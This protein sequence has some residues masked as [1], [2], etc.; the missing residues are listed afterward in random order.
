FL[1]GGASHFHDQ[2]PLS[3]FEQPHTKYTE[4]G[5]TV[6]NLPENFYSSDYFTDKMMQ[7]VSEQ[8]DDHPFFA[9]L[10]FTSPHDPLQVPDE[11]L[12]K[13][14]GMYDGG[15]DSIR[16]QRLQRMKE[17]G[18][19]SEELRQNEGSGMFKKW[20]ELTK[21]KRKEEARKMEI[22]AAMQENLDWNLGRLFD[23]LKELNK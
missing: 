19:V 2:H 6:E 18:L 14:K 23:R 20:E 7:Y 15:Y 8:Q 22:Y 4:D 10:A 12:D 21:E 13:Y 11:W 1:G 9:Y 3:A 17:L 16:T 5:K